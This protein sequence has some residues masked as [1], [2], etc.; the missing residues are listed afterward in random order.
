M[1]VK[2]WRRRAQ[3]AHPGTMCAAASI[4]P[5]EPRQLLAALLGTGLCGQYFNNSNFTQL[6]ETRVDRNVNFSNLL[7]S[8][9]S[10]VAP[11]TFAVRWSGLIETSATDTYTFYTRSDDGIRLWVNGRQIINNFTDH[12]LTENSGQIKLAANH[13]YSIRLDYYN[14]SGAAAAQ[15][16]WSRG[17]APAKTP[18]ANYYLY[19]DG[20]GDG[21]LGSYFDYSERPGVQDLYWGQ[22]MEMPDARRI[23]STINLNPGT[24]A[25]IEGV[26]DDQFSVRWSGQVQ[27]E[28]NETYTFYT[29]SD[30]GVRLFVDDK[31]IIDDYTDHSVVEDRAAISLRAGKRYDIRMEYYENTGTAAARLLW[32]SP[33]TRK[34]TVP[35]RVLFSGDDARMDWWRDARF[36][37]FVHFGLYSVLAGK[38]GAQV[39]P[40][41]SEWIMKDLNIP[42]K[43]YEQ[44]MQHF[45]PTGFDARNWVVAAKN[46]GMKYIVVTAKHHDG[47]CLFDSKMTSYDVMSTPFK[48][49][50]VKELA[51]AAHALG[52]KF[53]I[54]YSLLDWHHPDYAPR[55]DAGEDRAGDGDYG[56]YFLNYALPQV[57]ELLSNYG[58]VDILWIDGGWDHP[59]AEG[60]DQI[61]A[62]ARSLQPSII[63][64]NRAQVPGD[65]FTPEQDMSKLPAPGS[66]GDWEL[67]LTMN[68]SW[69]Y[70]A[71]DQNW[72]SG[73][74]LVR[75][76]VETT[77]RGGNLLLNVGPTATG[78]FPAASTQRLTSIGRWLRYNGE[79]IYGAGPET[80]VYGGGVSKVTARPGDQP[81]VY[82]YLYLHVYDWPL[83]RTLRVYGLDP[84]RIGK[85]FV[86]SDPTHP[87]VIFSK[88]LY[89]DIEYITLPAK[90]ADLRDTVI[91]LWMV[92]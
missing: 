49:D 77:R 16:L 59:A 1:N 41:S 92:S 3:L 53:G 57:R 47:F 26:G 76:L 33:S 74:T 37:M 58:R 52:M 67:C 65:F 2:T 39:T 13:R 68:D 20:K 55:R 70:K 50:L 54:Y 63:I 9:P 18:V 61:I 56:K 30:D 73:T 19:P 79:S 38:W 72:K 15:L 4:E 40:G 62:T 45:N 28:F 22:G 21:L 34:Q 84:R 83:D 8:L 90:A 36:G 14:K 71:T 7:Q 43:Q 35:Q 12:R 51:N 6:V 31:L 69:G 24:S 89:H 60:A 10:G 85:A 91:A 27:P 11:T 25:P 82:Q 81:Y 87:S 66:P 75:D 86:L 64:N 32:S 42:S 17:G 80:G 78:I 48:R 44:T 23:D 29:R 46:A 88:E 5:L